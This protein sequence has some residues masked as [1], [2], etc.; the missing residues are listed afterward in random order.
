MPGRTLVRWLLLVAVP[1]VLVAVGLEWYARSTRWAETENAYVKANVVAVSAE[2][3]GRVTEVGVRDQQ[4]VEKGALLFAID[5]APYQLAVQRAEAELGVTRAAIETLRADYRTALRETEEANSRITFLARQLERQ[6]MLKEKGMTREELYDD[7]KNNL[8]TAQKRVASLKESSSRALAALD[9][10][11]GAPVEAHP[12]YKQALAMLETAQL[13]LKRTRITAPV[14]GVVSNM[15]LQPGMHVER[16]ASIFSLVEEGPLWIEANYK[17]TQLTDM[18]VGQPASFTVDAY[19]GA[20]WRARV[21]AIAPATGAEFAV[22]PPQNATGNWVKVVQRV[23]V[24]IEV[25]E[26]AE[27]PPLRAGMT[28]IT[29]VDTGRE[30]SAVDL[31]RA[32]FL[33]AKAE[34]RR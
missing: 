18:R 3:S 13:D 20:I 16:G 1:A 12:R 7:A 8:D 11:P 6:R 17:E 21:V 4:R 15:R 26:S 33:P 22:L 28:V 14:K 19:P 27:R 10:K 2:V 24:R 30:R 25:E 31:L 29:S 23:P 32:F 9:G 5:P 34:A